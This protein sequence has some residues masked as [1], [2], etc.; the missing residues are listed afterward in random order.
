MDKLKQKKLEAKGWKIGDIDE[1]LGLDKAE[2]AIVEMK[3]TLS[4]AIIE[5]RKKAKLTQ[6][7]M[8]KAIGSSQSRVAKIE[9]ADPTVSIELMLKSLIS[10][11]TSTKEIA[12]MIS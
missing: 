11:G 12:K 1:F 9:H 7:Q 5:K 4:K 8:A 6:G 3:F 2:M 10:M